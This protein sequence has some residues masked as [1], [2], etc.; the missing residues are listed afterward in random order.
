MLLLVNLCKHYKSKDAE[1]SSSFDPLEIPFIPR[2]LSLKSEN[3]Q[4]FT[5]QVS[6][7]KKKSTYKYKAITFSNGSPED[8]LE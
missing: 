8:V 2:A 7:T 5:L 4:E 1:S 6:P 3:T